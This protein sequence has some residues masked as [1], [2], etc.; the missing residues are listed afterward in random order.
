MAGRIP[1]VPVTQC[2]LSREGPETEGAEGSSMIDIDIDVS[3]LTA[4]AEQFRQLDLQP[5]RGV[6]EAV[7]IR[8]RA[9]SG[10]MKISF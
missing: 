10:N 1:L 6:R 2:D 9:I 3:E 8:R 4:L 7:G 5:A